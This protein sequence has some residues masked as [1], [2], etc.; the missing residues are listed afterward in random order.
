MDDYKVGFTIQLSARWRHLEVRAA[1]VDSPL[2][3]ELLLK[4]VVYADL[5]GAKRILPDLARQG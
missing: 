2:R 3:A 1:V 4:Q 5:R